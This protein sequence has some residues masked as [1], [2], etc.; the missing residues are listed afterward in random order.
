MEESSPCASRRSI[1]G[2]KL[3]KL[4]A[5]ANDCLGERR[6][7]Y[8]QILEMKLAREDRFRQGRLKSAAADSVADADDG[9]VGPAA[10][11]GISLSMRRQKK[12]GRVPL[13]R[14][15]SLLYATLLT[16]QNLASGGSASPSTQGAAENAV[17]N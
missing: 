9:G 12:K 17:R 3:P 1:S 4:T 7:F 10:G 14:A 13:E 15:L 2:E 16:L 5:L 8:F 6:S 11:E